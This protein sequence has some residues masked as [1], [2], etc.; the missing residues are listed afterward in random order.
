MFENIALFSSPLNG[1]FFL[2]LQLEVIILDLGPEN[3]FVKKGRVSFSLTETLAF[4][5]LFH[6]EDT[7]SGQSN[8]NIPLPPNGNKTHFHNKGF[9]LSL[10]LKVRFF[11]TRKWPF[12]L[13]KRFSSVQGFSEGHRNKWLDCV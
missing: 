2:F 11:G 1:I 10:V 5:V 7:E 4:T 13:G 8:P 3:S 9:A 12:L 6:Q